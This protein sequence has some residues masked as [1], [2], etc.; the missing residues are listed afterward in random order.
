[1]LQNFFKNNNLTKQTK[2]KTKEHNNVQN[3]NI[4]IRNLDSNK[5]R[6]KAHEHFLKESV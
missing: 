4:C 6:E 2:I 5:E 3:V 1:M